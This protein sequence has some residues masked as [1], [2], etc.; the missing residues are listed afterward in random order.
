MYG[1]LNSASCDNHVI[2]H[3]LLMCCV[4]DIVSVPTCA[5]QQ[6]YD[7]HC[8]PVWCHFAG[9]IHANHGQNMMEYLTKETR[10]HT[11]EVVRHGGCLGLGLAAMGTADIGY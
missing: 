8:L 3:F 11:E 4:T 9:L 7:E 1:A 5:H 6:K 10:S 2:Y